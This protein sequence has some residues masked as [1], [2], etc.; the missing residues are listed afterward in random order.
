MSYGIRSRNGSVHGL[1][2]F[3]PRS[4]GGLGVWSP[5]ALAT[6]G[7]DPG[8]GGMHC[9][10]LDSGCVAQQNAASNAYVQAVQQAQ[11]VNNYDQCAANAQNA[12]SQEQYDSTMARC[13]GQ[14]AIQS[15]PQAGDVATIPARTVPYVTPVQPV[16]VAAPW[17]NQPAVQPWSGSVASG[18]GAGSQ[19]LAPVTSAPVSTAVVKQAA[20]LSTATAGTAA[21]ISTP[22]VVGGFDLSTIPWWGWA[23]AAA[24]A[25]FAFGKGR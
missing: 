8:G 11:V 1:G 6:Y 17:V 21:A 12:N 20:P 4:V 22:L 14:A 23:G 19:A 16:T 25:F 24:V 2:I 5:P 13:E 9:D 3:N 7:L 15:A 10:P 18:A